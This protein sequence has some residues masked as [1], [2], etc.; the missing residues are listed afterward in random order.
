VTAKEWSKE[1]ERPH[2]LLKYLEGE[3]AM[4]LVADLA[5]AEA[6][7]KA[8]EPYLLHLGDCEYWMHREMNA[9][10][11]CGLDAVKGGKG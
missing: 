8:L 6:R 11:T 9:P 10:C 5:S 4:R 7:I 3:D 2:G 1:I